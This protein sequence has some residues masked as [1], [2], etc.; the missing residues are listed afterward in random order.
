MMGGQKMKTRE[1]LT[2][3]SDKELSYKTEMDMGKGLTVVGEDSC[4]K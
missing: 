1:T 3:K 4:K 2:K